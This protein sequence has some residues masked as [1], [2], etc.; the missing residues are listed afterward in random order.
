MKVEVRVDFGRGAVEVRGDGRDVSVEFFEY[1]S[2][3]GC[4]GKTERLCS[5]E[6]AELRRLARA[7][8]RVADLLEEETC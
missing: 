3:Y 4:H 6:P 2:E 8:G 7:L 1:R 5:D